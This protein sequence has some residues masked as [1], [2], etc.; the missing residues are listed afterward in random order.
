M[1]TIIQRV[2]SASVIADG[3]PTGSVG[4]GLF[5]LLGVVAG[6]TQADADKLAGKI[7]R[8]RIFPDEEG[9]NNLSVNDVKGG[10]LVVSNFTL[11]ANCRRGNRPDYTA[12]AP[13]KEANELYEYFVAC[14]GEEMRGEVACGVFGASME[15]SAKCD[16]P[17]TIVLDSGEM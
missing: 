14:L 9:R 1:K 7:A 11:A 2:T 6:D 17:I 12:A 4:K 15:I 10:A 16:G 8:M 5:I 13:P 3:V